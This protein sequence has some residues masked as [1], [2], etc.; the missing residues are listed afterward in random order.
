M[1]GSS[2]LG[3]IKS[4]PSPFPP[5]LAVL[6]LLVKSLEI[7]VCFKSSAGFM[8]GGLAIYFAPW[9]LLVYSATPILLHQTRFT[10]QGYCTASL[11]LVT[12]TTNHHRIVMCSIKIT[13][14]QQISR[15]QTPTPQTYC[16]NSGSRSSPDQSVPVTSSPS[17]GPSPSVFATAPSSTPSL[18]PFFRS[19]IAA[20]SPSG[21]A[22]VLRAALSD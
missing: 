10:N 21:L 4:P 17:K 2:S 8:Q 3:S 12:C 14:Q 20:N 13:K 18:I 15:K 7:G 5:N 16:H 22:C 9:R 19:I 11:G 6:S 1:S